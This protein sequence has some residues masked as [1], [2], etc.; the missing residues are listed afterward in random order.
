LACWG[1]KEGAAL[2]AWLGRAGCC[3]RSARRLA[4]ALRSRVAPPA[5]RVADQRLVA[6]EVT[7]GSIA[8]GPVSVAL[9]SSAARCSAEIGARAAALTLI[10]KLARAIDD[11]ADGGELPF[12][13]AVASFD[14]L[15]PGRDRAEWLQVMVADAMVT[16]NC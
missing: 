5:L 3:D 13:P 1:A 9:L 11:G 14:A 12:L 16:L 10:G 15:P 8:S 6:A 4:H 2:A 7:A